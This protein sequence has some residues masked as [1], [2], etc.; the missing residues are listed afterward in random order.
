MLHNI[1]QEIFYDNPEDAI[2]IILN[3]YKVYFDKITK[4][5]ESLLNNEMENSYQVKAAL[6]TLGACLL[7]LKPICEHAKVLAR[8]VKNRAL[9]LHRNEYLKNPDKI[10]IKDAKGNE[11]EK[12]VL[13]SSTVSE[14]YG[15]AE[16]SLFNRVYSFLV[17]YITACETNVMILQ[18]LLK[19]VAL[20]NAIYARNNNGGVDSVTDGVEIIEDD[21]IEENL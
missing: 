9:V 8:D 13:Y 2:T 11:K 1:F 10:K 15:D 5:Q 17:G 14:A 12:D 16:A 21:D 20:E 7:A 18:S 19:S 6:T 3:K 4:V